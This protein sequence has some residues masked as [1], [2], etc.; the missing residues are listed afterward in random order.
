MQE[1]FVIFGNPVAHSKSPQM[2]NAGFE[3][4]NYN[5]VYKKHHLEDGATIKTAF[6]ENSYKGA[7]ITVPHKEFAYKN[8]DEVR[9]LAN[10]IQAVNTYINE[11]GKVIAYNTDAPGFLKAIESFKEVKNVLLLGAGGTAKAIALA[12]QEKGIK[13]TVLNRSAGKLEFFK[14]EGITSYSWDDFKPEEYDLV[15]NSTSAGL[16]DEHLPCDKEILEP[17]LE[18]ASFAFDCVYGKITPFLALAKQNDCEIKDGED[19]LLFQGVLAF[20]YFTKQNVGDDVVEAMRKG[21][22]G[23]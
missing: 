8:A 18:K 19:M 5:G 13:V 22:K 20:E 1:K 3:A 9:G 12:L 21:L 10:K 15:V 4:L 17:I 2:Q 6:L 16:K 23:E 14:N 11:N 7:N